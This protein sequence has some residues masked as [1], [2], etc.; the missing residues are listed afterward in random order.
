MCGFMALLTTRGERVSERHREAVDRGLFR[1]RQRGPDGESTWTGEGVLLGHRRLSIIDLD[2]RAA[3]P[4]SSA[5]GRY[6]IA[7]NGEIYNHE[8]LR[9]DLEAKGARFRTTSDT[10]VILRLFADEGAAMLPRLHGMFA[11]TIWDTLERRAFVARDP[12]GI[13]P[14][15][16]A[17][18][19]GGIA[20]ASQVKALLETGLVSREPDPRGQAGFWML[21]SVPE[22]R[23]WFRA[24]RAFRAG[25]CAWIEGGR[26]VRETC[27]H[28][29]GD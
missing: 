3:Q 21:G 12:Y 28:D 24:I 8:A 7:F 9:A 23:T 6:V 20:L 1:M 17:D 19:P 10:E 15:F 11:F 18:F 13:K 4:M 26:M 2:A 16:V 29:I 27:W 25:H 22:P 14:L 5:D